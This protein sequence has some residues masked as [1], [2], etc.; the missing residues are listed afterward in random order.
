LYMPPALL[1][2]SVIGKLANSVLRLLEGAQVVHVSLTSLN[3]IGIPQDRGILTVIASRFQAL[4][5]ASTVGSKETTGDGPNGDISAG[6]SARLRDSLGDLLHE[7]SRI[8]DKGSRRGFVSS[9]PVSRRVGE[10]TLA[11]F[12]YIYNHQTGQKPVLGRGTTTVNLDAAITLTCDS[13]MTLVHP[14]MRHPIHRSD[15]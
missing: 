3:F 9:P 1:H 12:C 13:Q 2:C 6:S 8:T 7:N 14:G 15:V 4:A 10:D 11:P 5:S